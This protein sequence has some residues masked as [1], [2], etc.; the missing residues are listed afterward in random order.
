M[1]QENFK[2]PEFSVEGAN[3]R[4]HPSSR[5]DLLEQS[6]LSRLPQRKPFPPKTSA[7]CVGCDVRLDLFDPVQMA[8][9]ACR[10]C[11]GI[12]GKLGAAFDEKEKR[13]RRETLERFTGGVE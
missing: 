13:E 3:S 1:N 8:I 7:V 11:I 5:R 12:Y 9:Q 4:A 2:L 10:K 6:K